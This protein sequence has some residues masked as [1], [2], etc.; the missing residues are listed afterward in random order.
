[1]PYREEL[2]GL[3][4][5]LAPLVVFAG[6][7]LLGLVVRAI[8]FRML[9]R[10]A[11]RTPTRID[12]IVLAS[13]R[14][15]SYLWILILA[16]LAAFQVVDLPGEQADVAVRRGLAALLV[17]SI[18]MGAS[19]LVSELVQLHGSGAAPGVGFASSGIQRTAARL[20]VVLVGLLV[21]LSTLGIQIGPIL[22]ALGVG[23]LAAGLALQ[24]TLSNLF[25]GFQI[26]SA[27]QVRI[28]DRVRLSSGEDGYITDI[29]WRATTLRTPQNHLVIIPNSKFAESIVTNVNLPDP[30]V[31]IPIPVS[32]SYE[33]DPARVEEI[34]RDEARRAIA[35][36]EEF[37]K[38]SEPIV[39]LQA[40]G[41]SSLDFQVILSVR[42]FD[43]QFAVWGDLLQRIFARLARERITI[44]YP[45]R[46]VQVRGELPAKPRS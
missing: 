4:Q 25:A 15:P 42:D 34:L 44:P 41:Q 37:V 33:S 7:L 3:G 39:R 14:W 26:A 38:G 27:R 45:T 16:L 1:M 23:G 18:T 12:D 8:S 21:M 13:T 6:V 17:L 46:T 28:G 11:S 2:R 22:G 36:R 9:G 29:S 10:W 30:R 43:A 24:P 19:R 35:E 5:W 32:V 40:F 20:L 31:N